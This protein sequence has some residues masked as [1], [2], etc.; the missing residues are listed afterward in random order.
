MAGM[1]KDSQ[2]L[3]YA[4]GG[5]RVTRDF[6]VREDLHIGCPDGNVDM[7][8]P[9]LKAA[10]Q[11]VPRVERV[12]KYND[13]G[14]VGF[15]CT[16]NMAGASLDAVKLKAFYAEVA[17]ELVAAALAKIATDGQPTT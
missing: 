1:T 15:V 8:T 3:V 9:G 12:L 16:L 10:L 4:E 14:V 11:D 6:L 5:L 7:G 17:A 13:K 2:R